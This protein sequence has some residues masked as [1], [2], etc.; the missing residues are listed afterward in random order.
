MDYCSSLFIVAARLPKNREKGLYWSFGVDDLSFLVDDG[1]TSQVSVFTKH[2]LQVHWFR[3]LTRLFVVLL[4]HSYLHFIC[5]STTITQVNQCCEA[6]SLKKQRSFFCQFIWF[7][8]SI[9]EV[10][11]PNISNICNSHFSLPNQIYMVSNAHSSPKK[12]TCRSIFFLVIRL[13]VEYILFS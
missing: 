7:I 4:M 2:G 10:G 13:I 3:F 1:A 5:T 6:I 9:N 8:R 12:P 11:K